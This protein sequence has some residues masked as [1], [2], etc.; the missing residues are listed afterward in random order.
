MKNVEIKAVLVWTDP[1][2]SA[3]AYISL[4]NNLNL[5]LD[6]NNTIVYGNA[7][8]FGSSLQV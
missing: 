7:M 6:V 2:A 8:L 5:E 3:A 1:P 4:V